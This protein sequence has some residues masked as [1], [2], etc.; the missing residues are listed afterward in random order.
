MRILLLPSMHDPIYG[1]D[2]FY[3]NSFIA[4]LQQNNH[5]TAVCASNA[6]AFDNTTFYYSPRPKKKLFSHVSRTVED[7]LYQAGALSYSY[8]REDFQSIQNAI[9]SFQPHLIIEMNRPAGIICARDNQLPIYSLVH[10]NLYRARNFPSHILKDLNRIL[11]NVHMEQVLR[12]KDLYQ[13]A[14]HRFTFGPKILQPFITNDPID[15]L[16]EIAHTYTRSDYSLCYIHMN[17]TNLSVN[18]LQSI[19]Q[20]SFLGAPYEVYAYHPKFKNSVVENIHFIHE[21]S[22]N[23]ISRSKCVIHDGNTFMMNQ[24]ISQIVPQIILTDQS[25]SRSSNATAVSRAN[26]GLSINEKEVT[27]ENLYETFRSILSDD[28]YLE[29]ISDLHQEC[30][31]YPNLNQLF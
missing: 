26:V 3:T 24:C 20:D 16:G 6:T 27:M 17:E 8:L 23:L 10:S 19:I 29:T 22:L 21:P 14:T 12:L 31:Q 2:I 11:L 28:I 18:K 4:L 30:L 9:D 15:Y 25:I 13:Y 1:S 7:T 5:E